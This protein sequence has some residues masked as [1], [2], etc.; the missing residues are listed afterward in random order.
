MSKK[1]R[2]KKKKKKE[3]TKTVEEDRLNSK[4]ASQENERIEEDGKNKHHEITSENTNKGKDYKAVEC[5]N[6]V[7]QLKESMTAEDEEI[8]EILNKLS[9]LNIS[10]DI[11]ERNSV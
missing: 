6:E 10:K 4:Q 3:K 8:I 5:K 7:I 9:V 1:C 11:K 2:L